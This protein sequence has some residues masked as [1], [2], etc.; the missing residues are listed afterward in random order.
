MS[1]NNTEIKTVPS[2]NYQLAEIVAGFKEVLQKCGAT[3]HPAVEFTFI[4]QKLEKEG[5]R[6]LPQ[7]CKHKCWYAP[8]TN[9][10]QCGIVCSI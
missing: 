5:S 3:D 7:G 2:I 6:V 8:A 4:N 9:S 1:E 10:T